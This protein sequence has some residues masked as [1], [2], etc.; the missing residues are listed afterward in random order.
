MLLV[1]STE[2]SEQIINKVSG[3]I[4]EYGLK[5]LVVDPVFVSAACGSK[6]WL[7]LVE[8]NTGSTT[9]FLSP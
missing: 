9:R 1:L 6:S 4:K 2:I 5:N 3:K 7:P 8:T